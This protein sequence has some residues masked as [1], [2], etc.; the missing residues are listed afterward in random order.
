MDICILRGFFQASGQKVG[1]GEFLVDFLS[2]LELLTRHFGEVE[3]L[4]DV[5]QVF[6]PSDIR[7]R[8]CGINKGHCVFIFYPF[9]IKLLH[10]V[11]QYCLISHLFFVKKINM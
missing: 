10:K 2:V 6:I 9:P 8:A 5:E 7:L 4:G 1:C 11:G 3:I